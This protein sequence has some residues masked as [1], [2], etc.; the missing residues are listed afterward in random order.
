MLPNSI[1]FKL[2][3]LRYYRLRRPSK[4][5]DKLTQVAYSA[6]YDAQCHNELSQSVC[7][8]VTSHPD[9]AADAT[10]RAGQTHE[11]LA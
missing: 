5:Q 8:A 9:A 10:S 2:A 1:S 4:C 3:V 11:R 6:S 7:L